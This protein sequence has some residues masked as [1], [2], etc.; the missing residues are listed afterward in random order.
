[1]NLMS[2]CKSS[3]H[4]GLGGSIVEDHQDFEG[5]ALRR[6]MLL[7]LLD[8]LRLTVSLE[9]LA[10]HPTTG[11]DEPVDRQAGLIITLECTRVLD[12]VLQDGRQLAV[13]RQVSLQ[14]EG[15]TVLER[16]EARG[17]L[18]LPRDV[19]AF[20]QL[21]LQTCFIHVKHLLRLVNPP[22]PPSMMTLRRS[23]YEAVVSLS[24]LLASPEHLTLQNA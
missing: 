17:R 22:P 11:V 3:Q 13:S 12:V 6:A 23:G 19:R 18:L 21:P 24:A 1:M 9:N 2:E 7:Q 14:E 20:R 16:F 10:R 8:Q 4:L 15:E 5:E